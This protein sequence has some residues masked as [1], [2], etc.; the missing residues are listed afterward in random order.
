[1]TLGTEG[2][3]KSV[4]MGVIAATAIAGSATAG[5]WRMLSYSQSHMSALDRDSLRSSGN[6]RNGWVVFILPSE[7]PMDYFVTRYEWDCSVGRARQIHMVAYRDGE[8]IHEEAGSGESEA[9]TPDSD[10]ATTLQA[11]CDGIDPAPNHSGWNSIA[12]IV[13]NYRATL[14]PK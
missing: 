2:L 6:L 9:V 12:D 5:D 10:E 11:V 3:M 4:V 1:M 13:D 14:P 7:M 8:A